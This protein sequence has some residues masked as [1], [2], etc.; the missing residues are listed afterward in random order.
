M[1]QG[2][3]LRKVVAL[4]LSVGTSTATGSV[5]A[6]LLTKFLADLTGKYLENLDLEE[7]R[8][9]LR[10][11]HP[12]DLNNHLRKA[13][14]KA[15]NKA[16]TNV[17]TL[18]GDQLRYEYEKAAAKKLIDR[19]RAEVETALLSPATKTDWGVVE[20]ID[21]QTVQSADELIESF[22]AALNQLPAINKQGPLPAFIRAQFVPQLQ[23]CFGEELK[24]P[25]QHEAWVAYQRLLLGQLKQSIKET[26][27]LSRK[28]N[29]QLGE[30]ANQQPVQIPRVSKER[31]VALQDLLTTLD[32]T[33]IRL[34]DRFQSALDAW[35]A[36]LREQMNEVVAVS[37]ETG[38]KVDTLSRQVE[39]TGTTVQTFDRTL[40]RNW[41]S[42]YWLAMTITAA[43]ILIGVLVRYTYIHSQ[44][45]D[46]TVFIRPAE[47]LVLATDYPAF[48]GGELVLR[49]GNKD[50]RIQVPVQ[51]EV[52]VKQIPARL[53]SYAVAV[54]VSALHWKA[55]QDS[56]VLTGPVLNLPLVPD[57][58]LGILTGNVRNEA[59]NPV[60]AA[61][62]TIN[63]DTTIYTD[64]RG[65]FRLVLP[66]RIQHD[67]YA[68]KVDK[69]G[70]WSYERR[71]YPKSG[72]IDVRLMRIR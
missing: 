9:V 30:L 20:L 51:G 13:L 21:V 24:N 71:Y 6:G 7:I 48:V 65:V 32:L 3:L 18:Y 60:V 56:V 23:L 70:Y 57:G 28:A 63:N 62:V 40:R 55:T 2:K 26:L 46:L 8:E 44:P 43:V 50:E 39:Q 41:V 16:L 22:G 68:L 12:S 19:L 49:L 54:R 1:K 17:Q 58:S 61:A 10:Q 33:E 15:I 27:A 29:W 42:K 69:P 38:R 11:T 35:V 66:H 36:D 14:Q 34:E 53:Q 45:F 25:Q 37:R 4:T 67:N 59:A 64:K 47:D 72:N 31:L 5:G 52:V